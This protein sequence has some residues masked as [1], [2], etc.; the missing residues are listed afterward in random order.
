MLISNAATA[1]LHL[2]LRQD[3]DALDMPNGEICQRLR[4]YQSLR[5]LDAYISHYLGLPASLP[6]ASSARGSLSGSEQR[7]PTR[8]DPDE[9]AKAIDQILTIFAS[10]QQRAYFTDMNVSQGSTHRVPTH[11]IRESG[12]RFDSWTE[13]NHG[14]MLNNRLRWVAATCR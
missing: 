5:T 7:Q 6:V 2:G 4:T 12:Q 1:A 14:H 8:Y 3:S 10:T 13:L 11:I 9:E